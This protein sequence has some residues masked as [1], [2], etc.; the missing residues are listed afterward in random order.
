MSLRRLAEQL[1]INSASIRRH[2]VRRRDLIEAMAMAMLK[3]VETPLPANAGW[4]DVLRHRAVMVRRAMLS[5]RD[6][7][8]VMARGAPQSWD[9]AGSAALLAAGFT[10]A[11]AESALELIDRFVLGWVLSEQVRGPVPC[12]ADARFVARIDTILAAVAPKEAA[13]LLTRPAQPHFLTLR[14]WKVLHAARESADIAYSRTIKLIELDRQILLL[15]ESHGDLVPAE[16]SAS[17]GVDKAQVSRSVKRLEELGMIRRDGV[18]SPLALTPAGH[19]LTERMMRLA[20]LRNRELTFGINDEQ[21]VGFFA[22]LEH[23][24]A[25]AVLLLDQE[26]KLMAANR[27]EVSLGYDDLEDEDVSNGNMVVERARILPPMITLS[28]YAM[29]SAALAFKRL[30]GL[31]NFESWVLNE[32]ARDP[33]M[34]WNR[35]VQTVN[36]DQSQA[37]RTVKRLMEMGLVE[38]NGPPERRHGTF[39]PTAEGA[40]LHSLLEHAGRQ[41][42]EFLVQNLS[43]AQLDSFFVVFDIIAHNAEAQLNRERALDEVERAA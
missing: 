6:G 30:T 11:Q 42:S 37:G 38:R 32:I 9:D 24:M 5:H 39:L 33:P 29:R 12:D 25:R 36:R 41:R 13:A 20:E 1:A 4:C 15:L 17:M 14:L 43:E 7:S 34:E 26:R 28:S 35:L 21:L 18:R 23:L 2:F 19:N 22:V 8:L 31:S 27:P 40:R 3:H 10:E 16:V